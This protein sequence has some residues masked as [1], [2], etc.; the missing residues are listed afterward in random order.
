MKSALKKCLHTNPDR[1]S[2]SA[3]SDPEAF[4]V[5]MIQYLKV[6]DKSFSILQATRGLRRVSPSLVSLIVAGKRKLTFDRIEEISKILKLE[7]EEKIQIKQMILKR[8]S[9]GRNALLLDSVECKRPTVNR[10]KE[11]S[12]HLLNDWL[13]VYVK[14]CFQFPIF[15]RRPELVIDHL[16]LLAKPKRIKKS[17]QYLIANGYLRKLLDGRIVVESNLTITESPLP[18]KK[19][20]AFHKKAMKHAEKALELFSIHERMA[21]TFLMPLNEE[22]YRE[23]LTLIRDFNQ[24]TMS[25]A[26]QDE[27]AESRLYQL[28]LN[29]SPVGGKVK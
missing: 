9:P 17:I 29:L 7:T 14:D 20:R 15:Q 22:R 26:D 11:A 13:N 18:S 2:L 6:T 24:K 16:E 23:L 1:P 28:V 27:N 8:S 10:R 19:I 4:I 5:Q 12:V 25:I 21:N 3:F